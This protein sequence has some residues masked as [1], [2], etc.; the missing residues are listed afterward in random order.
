MAVVLRNVF[1]WCEVSIDQGEVVAGDDNVAHFLQMRLRAYISD[2]TYYPDPDEG[3]ARW[4]LLQYGGEVASYVPPK[5]EHVPAER[6]P[7][8]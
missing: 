6:E 3:L 1:G 4:L 8:Y 5:R 2:G 7:I